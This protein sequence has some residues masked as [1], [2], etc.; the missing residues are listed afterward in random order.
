MPDA[1]GVDKARCAR[2][3]TSTCTTTTDARRLAPTRSPHYDCRIRRQREG[4]TLQAR[5]SAD[6]P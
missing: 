5:S 2:A 6:E 4:A 1:C 3:R